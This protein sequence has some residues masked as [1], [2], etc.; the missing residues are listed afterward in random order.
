MCLFLSYFY[1]SSTPYVTNIV[2]SQDVWKIGTRHL[3][4]KSQNFSSGL[5][6]LMVE[7]VKINAF[8]QRRHVVWKIFTSC[9]VVAFIFMIDSEDSSITVNVFWTTWHNIPEEKSM[10]C[11]AG[12]TYA[13][14]RLWSWGYVKRGLGRGYQHFR[15]TCCHLPQSWRGWNKGAARLSL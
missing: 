7:P 10:Q 3:I 1:P 8:W 4:L 5:E 14:C 13:V 11:R 6:V 2:H 9:W 15:G 12:A